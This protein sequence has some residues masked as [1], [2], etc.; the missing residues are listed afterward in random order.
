MKKTNIQIKQMK[1]SDF[2]EIFLLWKKAGLNVLS[3]EIEFYEAKN[4]IKLNPDSCFVLVKNEKI[5]GSILGVFNGRRG[6]IY[7]L[8]IDPDFQKKGYGSLLLKKTENALKKQGARRVNL[9]VEYENLKVFPFYQKYG[10]EVIN[11]ALWLGK[12][13]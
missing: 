6:W 11:N 2:S 4:M 10:Y 8:A 13:I 3:E 9:G 1:I 5:I 12:N 7:H